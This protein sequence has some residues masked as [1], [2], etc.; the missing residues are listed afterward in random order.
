MGAAREGTRRRPNETTFEHLYRAHSREVYGVALA[1]L[2]DRRDAEDATQTAFLNAYRALR[3]GERPE[4]P[5]AWLYAIVRNVCRRLGARAERPVELSETISAHRAADTPTADEIIGALAHLTDAQRRAFVLHDVQGLSSTETAERLGLSRAAA[6]GLLHRAR[7][8]L[9]EQLE[10]G[11]APLACADAKQIAARQLEGVASWSER[12]ALRAHLRACAPC[13][14]DARRR[15][16]RAAASRGFSLAPV[17][18]GLASL[19]GRSAPATSMAT[20]VGAAAIG[21]S[22]VALP[23]GDRPVRAA[24]E[25]VRPAAAAPAPALAPETGFNER[26]G[27][28][29]RTASADRPLGKASERAGRRAGPTRRVRRGA[30]NSE[31]AASTGTSVSDSAPAAS[32]APTAGQSA[33]PAPTPQRQALPVPAAD[34]PVRSPVPVPATPAPPSPPPLP[35]L[36]VTPPVSAPPLPVQ[37]PPL[38]NPAGAVP[39]LP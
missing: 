4:R 15:R 32:A 36:P 29:V 20:V 39:K 25:N 2:R 17:L 9:R 31:A 23:A 10:A 8:T 11:E 27:R 22:V 14:A 19:A 5:R 24:A 1:E 16:A 33:G 7:A 28:T 34:L 37:P 6:D 26:T 12:R 13:A 18:H 30:G 3:R 21:T 35:P 38:P